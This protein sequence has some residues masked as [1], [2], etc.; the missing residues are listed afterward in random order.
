MPRR[1]KICFEA[2]I[3]SIG[4]KLPD[5]PPK[6]RR[7]KAYT[8][9]EEIKEEVQEVQEIG[10]KQDVFDGLAMK[11]K[12]GYTKDDLIKN[13]SGSII[14]KPRPKEKK[15]KKPKEKKLSKKEQAIKDFEDMSVE[16]HIEVL[17][18]LVLEHERIQTPYDKLM[19]LEDWGKIQTKQA[20]DYQK[21]IQSLKDTMRKHM[22]R[23]KVLDP[24]KLKEYKE[25]QRQRQK[26][27][28][29]EKEEAF[30]KTKEYREQK[31]KELREQKEREKEEEM[32]ESASARLQNL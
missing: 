11:T 6:L 1:K 32:Y 24:Q 27:I 9:K 14:L 5:K 18:P 22:E 21:Q 23:I 13:D 20:K 29:K 12:R 30:K 10:S 4:D 8:K 7:Q 17:K 16:Q 3:E 25:T 15:E 19:D 2:T 26:K 28:R 31:R